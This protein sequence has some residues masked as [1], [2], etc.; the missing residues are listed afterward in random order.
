MD[1]YRRARGNRTFRFTSAAPVTIEDIPN[2]LKQRMWLETDRVYR[3]LPP[4]ASC[5]L[6]PASR[7]KPPDRES[8][9]RFLQRRK[10]RS[11]RIAH[12]QPAVG[13]GRS[14]NKPPRD[15]SRDFRDYPDLLSS[16]RSDLHSA[17]RP[18]ASPAPKAP[19]SNRAAASPLIIISASASKPDGMDVS[20]FDSFEAFT[21]DGL[22]DA[23]KVHAA[24]K[25]VATHVEDLLK[26]PIAEPFVGPANLSAAAPPA[27]LRPPRNLRSPHRR[28]PP[29][30]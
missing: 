20:D 27:C 24:I 19:K 8:V 29:E 2:A 9:R 22:P 26:A 7:S 4:I 13:G 14:G 10:L 11:H 28:P 18:N 1:N 17:D 3:A 21:A 30:G 16:S 6:K 12:Q 23:A 5:A 15:W 25:K